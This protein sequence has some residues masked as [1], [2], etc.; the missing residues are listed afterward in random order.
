[1]DIR[2]NI[3]AAL[4]EFS[5]KEALMLLLHQSTLR[6]INLSFKTIILAQSK[7]SKTVPVNSFNTSKEIFS[8]TCMEKSNTMNLW[9]SVKLKHS[10][11]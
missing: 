5:P 3:Q 11:L 4:R 6:N 10:S 8:A 7:Q 9:T 1:M 2:L